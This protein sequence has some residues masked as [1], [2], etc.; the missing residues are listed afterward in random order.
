MRKNTG[1][2]LFYFINKELPKWEEPLQKLLLQMA[3]GFVRVFNFSAIAAAIAYIKMTEDWKN[4]Y[5]NYVEIDSKNHPY[6]EI[7]KWCE[8]NPG[9]QHPLHRA[10]FE[11]AGR[12]TRKTIEKVF[13]NWIYH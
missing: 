11:N 8:E 2:R 12:E 5:K 13:F 6:D 1:Q 9:K 7:L 4:T 10:M 3:C